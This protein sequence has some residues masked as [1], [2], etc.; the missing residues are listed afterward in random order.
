MP[1]FHLHVHNRI[2]FVLDEEGQE[3]PDLHAARAVAISSIRSIVA[4]EAHDGVIDLTGRVDIAD[5][6]GR[7]LGD[8]PFREAFLVESGAE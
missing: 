2:G 6:A 4:E 1:R 8:V 3:L 7:V 5:H